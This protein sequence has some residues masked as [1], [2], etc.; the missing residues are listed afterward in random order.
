MAGSPLV[1]EGGTIISVV[2]TAV[3]SE[4]QR[5]DVEDVPVALGEVGGVLVVDQLDKLV[6]HV[7]DGPHSV[8]VRV[9]STGATVAW[10]R[11]APAANNRAARML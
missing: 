8:T 4:V 5:R 11:T 2:V 9:D 10:P 1:S 7:L 3:V 6:P